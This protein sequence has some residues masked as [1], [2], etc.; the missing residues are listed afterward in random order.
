MQSAGK[1][2]INQLSNFLYFELLRTF[3]INVFTHE[4][5]NLVTKMYFFQIFETSNLP[6][7]MENRENNPIEIAKCLK[8]KQVKIVDNFN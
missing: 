8:R 3:L 7:V 1:E 2:F 5:R 6:G 4:N